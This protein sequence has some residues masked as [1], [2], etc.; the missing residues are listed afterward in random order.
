MAGGIVLAEGWL[1]VSAI[2]LVLAALTIWFAN[3]RR[4]AREHRGF[5]PG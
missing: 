5:R 3:R 1:W 4:A 2:A